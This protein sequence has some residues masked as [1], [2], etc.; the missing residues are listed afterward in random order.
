MY[1]TPKRRFT[2]VSLSLLLYQLITFLLSMIIVS[3]TARHIHRLSQYHYLLDAAYIAMLASMLLTFLIVHFGFRNK[4]CLRL[5]LPVKEKPRAKE[6][7]ACFLLGF[8]MNIALTLLFQLLGEWF[9][10]NIGGGSFY[11]TREPLTNA[12]MLFTVVIAAPLFEEYLFRGVVLMTLQRYGSWFAI[13]LS[14]LLFALS[15][16]SITQAVCVFFLGFVIGY[17]SVKS[18]S[19]RLAILFHMLNNAIALLPMFFSSQLLS[20][21]FSL[22]LLV[23]AVIGVVLLICWIR[24]K[25]AFLRTWVTPYDYPIR[26]FFQNWASIVLLIVFAGLLLFNLFGA[27]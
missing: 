11:L 20:S 19:L 1:D 15:H 4:L 10:I 2:Y 7:I 26:C 17:L 12:L 5:H 22:L 13:V 18:G 23:I 3:T 21:L 24:R 6:V 16:G 27:L 8:G 25:D 14:S 9:S